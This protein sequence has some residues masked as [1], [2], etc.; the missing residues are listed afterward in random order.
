MRMKDINLAKK[1]DKTEA[2]G[3]KSESDSDDEDDGPPWDI[4]LVYNDKDESDMKIAYA[5]RKKLK[6]WKF[7]VTS[8]EEL[9]LGMDVFRAFEDR[10]GQTTCRLLFLTE[11]FS[12]SA[13]CRLRESTCIIDSLIKMDKSETG[14]AAY[15]VIPISYLQGKE[16]T[17]EPH[18]RSLTPAE[19]TGTYYYN[20]LKASIRRIIAD[21]GLEQFLN[22]PPAVPAEDPE[23]LLADEIAADVCPEL[24]E[25]AAK[26]DEADQVLALRDTTV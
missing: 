6:K 23:S 13:W 5:M 22:N 21:R 1:E 18:L 15:S 19:S 8:I 24:G 16:V 10:L 4:L 2:D 3:G 9:Q 25:I 20:N 11:S 7:T 12:K 17:L 26:E 14:V